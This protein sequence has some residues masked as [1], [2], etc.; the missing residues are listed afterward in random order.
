MQR[1][2]FSFCA[3]GVSDV[4]AD[5]WQENNRLPYVK[6]EVDLSE[7]GGIHQYHLVKENIDAKSIHGRTGYF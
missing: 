6:K 2:L 3:F 5:V 1:H 7:S 4:V